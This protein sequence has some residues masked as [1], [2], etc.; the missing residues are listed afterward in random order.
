MRILDRYICR[1]VLS[2]SLLGLAVFTFVFFVPQLVRLMDLIVRHSGGAGSITLLFL[3][4]LASGARVYAPDGGS[5][6]R[7][8]W[9]GAAVGR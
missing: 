5:G 7:P 2:H 9:P 1:E 6:R 8:D 4:S 3:C